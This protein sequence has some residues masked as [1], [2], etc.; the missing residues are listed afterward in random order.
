MICRLLPKRGA[1]RVGW[2]SKGA[3]AG[4]SPRDLM[5]SISSSSGDSR[6]SSRIVWPW[7]RPRGL[8][9]RDGQPGTEN[10]TAPCSTLRGRS[11]CRQLMLWPFA[12]P[13][14]VSTFARLSFL[15]K[16]ARTRHDACVPLA[17]RLYR[18]SHNRRS[19]P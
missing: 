10:E 9:S 18:A 16:D 12:D 11:R 19:G 3:L 13:K 4:R 14:A 15:A 5:A 8:A 2:Y 7:R 1:S 6:P 17:Y